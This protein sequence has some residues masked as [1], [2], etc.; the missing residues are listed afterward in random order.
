MS[1]VQITQL[2]AAQSVSGSEQIEAVQSGRS[3]SVTLNQ[4]AGLGIG[5]TGPTGPTGPGSNVPGPTGPTGRPGDPGSA[6]NYRG[7]V[8]TAA[9]LPTRA[10]NG[11]AFVALD[12][13]RIWAYNS[14]SSPFPPAPQGWVDVGPAGTSITGPTGPAGPKP[15]TFNYKGTVLSDQYLPKVG[16]VIGDVWVALNTYDQWAWG[17]TTWADIGPVAVGTP[18]P[19]G[20]TGPTGDIGPQGA[21]G[22][23]GATGQIGPTGN[24]GPQ[25]AA[26]PQGNTGPTGAPGQTANLRGQITNRKPNELP[27]NGLIPKDFDG[28]GEPPAPIQLAIG[29]GILYNGTADPADTG[30]LFVFNTGGLQVN[31]Y[32]NAGRIVGP[33]G[34]TGVQGPQGAQGFQGVA[35]PAGPQGIQGLPGGQGLRGVDGPQGPQGIQGEIG[36]RGN[37][38]PQG[39][40]G[41][42]GPTGA[43][44]STGATGPA[45]GGIKIKGDVPTSAQLP[46]TGN[47]NGDAYIVDADNSIWV[48]TGSKWYDMG[49]IAQGP[50]GAQG[51]AGPTGPA[52]DLPGPTGPAGN[53]GPTGPQGN[54][55]NQGNV[56]ATGP[57]GPTGPAGAVGG[58]GPV[59][60]TGP[61]GNTGSVGPTGPAGLPGAKGN[62]GLNFT[63][64]ILISTGA[65]DPAKGDQGWVWLQV[66]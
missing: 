50:T 41:V 21:T 64:T 11:D 42:T 7:V 14:I 54:T 55:G 19:T 13:D 39:Y 33:P 24:P 34:A 31:G 45:G 58:P 5:P 51:P 6:L 57:A 48:W 29:D 61:Q 52:S 62:D 36:P 63:S 26:G 20:P 47:T 30:C 23:V 3:V 44:G 66:S 12:T 37:T 46:A 32:I 28:P 53:T 27:Q 4:V 65:P 38:G 10:E 25:G 40:N 18:G 35:G 2:P 59:G 49:P 17:G 43:T 9:Q 56:G 15:G 1:D 60:P 16:N 8:Q 22:A